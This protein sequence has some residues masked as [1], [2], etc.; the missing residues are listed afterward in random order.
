MKHAERKQLQQDEFVSG[1][2]KFLDFV[3]THEKELLIS[4][5]VLVAVAVL[6][7][8]VLVI[9]N[10]GLKKE[11]RIVGE[12]IALRADI[13]KKPGN[14]ALLEKLAGRGKYQRVAYLHLATYW[15]EKGDLEK[16]EKQAGQVKPAPKDVI[17]YEAQDL[18]AQIASRKKNY[19]GALEIYARIEKEKPESYPLDAIL[20]HKAE[21]L[22][23]KGDTKEALA[24]FKKLQEEYAQTYF[25]YEASTKVSRLENAQ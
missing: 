10:R 19:A 24:V 9:R 17:Y 12:I 16:A 21:V 13:D 7:L 20:F 15:V 5:G 25:G 14:L 11:S 6:F 4:V 22:E 18:L 1:M 8:G 3:K 23:R 2:S